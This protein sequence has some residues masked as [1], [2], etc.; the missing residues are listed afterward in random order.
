MKCIPIPVMIRKNRWEPAMRS[1]TDCFRTTRPAEVSG[2]FNPS[3]YGADWPSLRL[4]PGFVQPA[5]WSSCG[6]N[7]CRKDSRKGKLDRGLRRA[8]ASATSL[9]SARSVRHRK[10]IWRISVLAGVVTSSRSELGAIRE[11]EPTAMRIVCWRFYATTSAIE[12]SSPFTSRTIRTYPAIARL[13]RQQR[14]MT[15]RFLNFWN[16]HPKWRL[17]KTSG[18]IVGR[19]A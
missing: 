6:D 5:A 1:E 7:E 2:P 3:L 19:V 15:L 16:R 4:L 12:A 14:K 18:T 10:N 8:G 17:R 13:Q 9:S 11:T